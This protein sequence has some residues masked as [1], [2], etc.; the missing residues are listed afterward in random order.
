MTDRFKDAPDLDSI[1]KE[2]FIFTMD[3]AKTTSEI[4]DYLAPR[5]V[6]EGFVVVDATEAEQLRK[7]RDEL[8]RLN[9]VVFNALYGLLCSKSPL[10]ITNAEKAISEMQKYNRDHISNCCIDDEGMR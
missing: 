6:R 10:T 5:I 8:A 2:L 9:N 7:E 1:K 3:Q 4:V